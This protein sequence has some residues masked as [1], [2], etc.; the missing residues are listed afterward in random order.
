MCT[1]IT[2][3]VHG[4]V[5]LLCSVCQMSRR[6][7]LIIHRRQRQRLNIEIQDELHSLVTV[8]FVCDF[9][10]VFVVL[11]LLYMSW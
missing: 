10:V 8:L 2:L 7:L 4:V 1:M 6:I 5:M 9:S 11:M 3:T